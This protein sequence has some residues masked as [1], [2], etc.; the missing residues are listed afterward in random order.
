MHNILAQITVADIGT[1]EQA[2]FKTV[3]DTSSSQTILEILKSFGV[4]GQI[5]GTETGPIVTSVY[6]APA[7]G[8]RINSITERTDDLQVALG[9]SSLKITLAPEKKAV[10]IEVPNPHPC[11]IPFG[12]IFHSAHNGMRLP[13]ALGVD[14]K[15]NPVYLDIAQT[16]HLLIAGQTGSGK[17]VC[18]NSIIVSLALHCR[19]VDLQFLLIDPKRVE[20]FPYEQMHNLI[21]GHVI[22]NVDE[23]IHSLKWLVQEMEVRNNILEKC[24]CR[25]INDFKKKLN[26]GQIEGMPIPYTQ[27]MPYIVAVIDE[28]ADLMMRSSKDLTDCIMALAQKARSVGIHLILATQRPST[29]VISGDIKANFP[30]RIALRTAVATDSSTIL[31]CGGA[32]KLL[33]KGDM[34]LSCDGD[35]RRI[36]GCYISDEEIDKAISALPSDNLFYFNNE[37]IFTTDFEAYISNQFK[38]RPTWGEINAV[39]KAALENLNDYFVQKEIAVNLNVCKEELADIWQQIRTACENPEICKQIIEHY[40]KKPTIAESKFVKF[41]IYTN[42]NFKDCEGNNPFITHILEKAINEGD[43]TA[44]I[45][46]GFFCNSIG[47]DN[48]LIKKEITAMC[49]SNEKAKEFIYEHFENFKS[50]IIE[51]AQSGDERAKSFL[52]SHYKDCAEFKELMIE[53]A[54]HLDEKAKDFVIQ[55]ASEFNESIVIW[56][57][58]DAERIF[59]SPLDHKFVI[60]D[61][62]IAGIKNAD[63]FICNLSR[64]YDGFRYR[65]GWLANE[66]NKKAIDFILNHH[67]FFEFIFS[68]KYK[69]FDG[70][71][72]VIYSRA[73]ERISA[74]KN[75]KAAK[76]LKCRHPELFKGFIIEWANGNDANALDSILNNYD[77][78]EEIIGDELKKSVYN[79]SYTRTNY[80]SND[81]KA[82][83]FFFKNIFLFDQFNNYRD[84]ISKW[85]NEGDLN[86]INFI[87]ENYTN[88]KKTIETWATHSEKDAKRFIFKH[89]IDFESTIINLAN[90]QEDQDTIKFICTHPYVFKD[91]IKDWAVNKNDQIAKQCIYSHPYYFNE[92]IKDWAVNKNDQI[93]K[94]CIYSDPS[95][96]NPYDFKDIIKDWANRNNDYKAK[97]IIYSNSILFKETIIEWANNNN[98]KAQIAIYNNPSNFNEIIFKWANDHKDERAINIIYSLPQHFEKSIVDWAENGNNNKARNFI[99]AYYDK[100]KE[101]MGGYHIFKD[102]MIKWANNGDVKAKEIVYK[103]SQVFKELLTDWADN[104]NDEKAKNIIYGHLH[105]NESENSI[106]N[107]I[108][109]P[110]N[111][112]DS[113]C[114]DFIKKEALEGNEYAQHIITS[115]DFLEIFG[116]FEEE[117]EL[118]LDLIIDFFVIHRDLDWVHDFICEWWWKH[119]EL[120]ETFFEWV[121]EGDPLARERFFERL[122]EDIDQYKALEN[123]DFRKTIILLTDEG[124][125]RTKKIIL[126]NFDFFKKDNVENSIIKWA[127]SGDKEAEDCIATIYTYYDKFEDSIIKLAESGDEKAVAII[128]NHYDEFK[129]SITKWANECNE[130]AQKLIRENVYQFKESL[131]SSAIA[132]KEWSKN[133]VLDSYYYYFKCKFNLNHYIVKWAEEG[134]ERAQKIKEDLDAQNREL[135]QDDLDYLTSLF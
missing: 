75:D 41:I 115:N 116:F 52:C 126:E 93:A 6:F 26:Q 117:S 24:R 1:F 69:A 127:E 88:F 121:R 61:W 42:F 73:T 105:N 84:A 76:I 13:A 98:P 40:I 34:L 58:N 113:T 8:I 122:D 109:N 83:E 94:Q 106:A 9:V 102:A 81:Q 39:C 43:K 62:A 37:N 63:K 20:F 65:L 92:T 110:D 5:V 28:Y 31:G 15:G 123:S 97:S 132:G 80:N 90:I 29:K 125:E 66:G 10:A 27:D 79:R 120:E 68:K 33:G 71:D 86:S 103:H 74:N 112:T 50:I 4:E 16:P 100:F 124:D 2:E 36:H 17:S 107:I 133:I 56:V 67:Q 128:Y 99:Y 95:N 19:P 38:D 82:K 108:D 111:W 119:R 104:K 114:I 30:T 46:V 77:L 135:D 32:E 51:W 59:K 134:D 60:V 11:K 21:S 129:D 72:S 44:L 14:T 25:N 131:I 57:K 91:I 87:Y 45:S 22:K 48:E 47:Y 118:N 70:L 54:Y 49:E 85:A 7:P 89:M 35:I 78:F 3:V 64:E 55:N 23:A 18:L 12:N 96:Y 53:Q 101:M 130:K